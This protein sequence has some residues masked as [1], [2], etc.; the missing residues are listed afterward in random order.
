MLDATIKQELTLEER[1]KKATMPAVLGILSLLIAGAVDIFLDAYWLDCLVIGLVFSIP[2]FSVAMFYLL[3]KTE[4]L[5]SVDE[6]VKLIKAQ[7]AKEDQKYDSLKL[8][9]TAVCV[10]IVLCVA[11]A[12]WEKIVEIYHSA[13]VK[14]AVVGLV[15]VAV[16]ATATIG[17]VCGWIYDKVASIPIS[18]AILFGATIIAF[19]VVVGA[20]KR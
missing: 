19:A 11:W 18:V 16:V 5:L 7:R 4:S 6:Q 10:L 17:Y 13:P 3:K 2:L 1:R 8:V 9:L 14:A 20:N 15:K 12:I